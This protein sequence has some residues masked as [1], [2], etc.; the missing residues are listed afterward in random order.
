MKVYA[1]KVLRS[2]G[3]VWR[4][5][6]WPAGPSL[7]P[8]HRGLSDVQVVNVFERTRRWGF[9][10]ARE[11]AE[12]AMLKARQVA[13][14]ELANNVEVSGW[15]GVERLVARSFARSRPGGCLPPLVPLG[16]VVGKPTA[17]APS[18]EGAGR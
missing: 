11:V 8:L 14:W 2:E 3:E 1:S 16:A 7:R 6:I 17:P 10:E 18:N 4:Y 12:M 13:E 5:D 9:Q 15:V